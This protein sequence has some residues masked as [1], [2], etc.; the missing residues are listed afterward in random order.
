MFPCLCGFGCQGSPC[1]PSVLCPFLFGSISLALL[2]PLGPG[3]V[4][5]STAGGRLSRVGCGSRCCGG[6]SL[7]PI[8]S[9][10]TVGHWVIGRPRNGS[11]GGQLELLLCRSLEFLVLT[12][13]TD[14]SAQ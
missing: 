13:L 7:F 4:G 5:G 1:F 14:H 3:G 2:S 12:L 9:L 6:S 11:R 8:L 10:V